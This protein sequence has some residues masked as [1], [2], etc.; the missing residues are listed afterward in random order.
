[1]KICG[2]LNATEIG[3]LKNFT[4]VSTPLLFSTVV[5]F[6]RA[7][8]ILNRVLVI[9]DIRAGLRGG[10]GNGCCGQIVQYLV[11]RARM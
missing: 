3:S 1:M 6:T 11:V 9:H 10:R 7:R 4:L 8:D 2:L 5:Y